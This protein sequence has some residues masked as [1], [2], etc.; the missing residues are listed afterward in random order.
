M[1]RHNLPCS[2]SGRLGPHSGHRTWSG[3][4]NTDS[5]SRLQIWSC[6]RCRRS[7]RRPGERPSSPSPWLA[8]SPSPC[9]WTTAAGHL[10]MRQKYNSFEGVSVYSEQDGRVHFILPS[11]QRMYFVPAIA[12]GPIRRLQ[13]LLQS[14][15]QKGR[16]WVSE[17]EIQRN[18]EE[19]RWVEERAGFMS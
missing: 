19:R 7:G 11:C 3:S 10:W 18:E 14:I 5:R 17:M 9:S 12:S 2:I 8:G 13:K 4:T 15:W 6:G 1:T 16:E